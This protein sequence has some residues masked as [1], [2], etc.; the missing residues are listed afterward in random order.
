M[1]KP[2]TLGT[3]VEQEIYDFYKKL[4]KVRME[5]VSTTIRIILRDYKDDCEK[6]EASH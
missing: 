6:I 4:A 3:K 2:K 5:K 1:I